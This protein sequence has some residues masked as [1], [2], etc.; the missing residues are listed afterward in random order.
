MKKTIMVVMMLLAA[1]IIIAGVFVDAKYIEPDRI[2]IAKN[3][4]NLTGRF[5]NPIKIILISDIHIGSEK[6]GDLQKKIQMINDQ[7]PDVVLIAG[8]FVNSQIDE[9]EE[10]RPLSALKA[11]YGKYA[12]LGNHDYGLWYSDPEKANDILAQTVSNELNKDG[13]TV[14]KNEFEEIRIDGKRFEL[15]GLDEQWSGRSKYNE[16]GLGIPKII[17]AH[18]QLAVDEK[19]IAQKTLILSG[20]THCGEIRIPIITDY[21]IKRY[22]GF[23]NTVG[24][25]NKRNEHIDEYV[26][27]GLTRGTTGFRFLTNPEITIIDIY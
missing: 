23:G 15:Y 19:Q 25:W 18:E 22:S 2:I 17:L 3:S 24:G 10:L 14:L 1:I 20:H 26:T 11:K 4:Y 5:S 6:E 27:C 9:V 8:D 7:N 13:I 21:L 12:V 16:S